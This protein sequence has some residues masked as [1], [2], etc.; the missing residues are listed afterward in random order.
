MYGSHTK[1]N[2]EL[3][4]GQTE[5]D[6]TYAHRIVAEAVNLSRAYPPGPVHINVP[7]REPFYPTAEETFTFDQAAK[8]ISVVSGEPTLS[9]DTVQALADDWARYEKKLIVGGQGIPDTELAKVIGQLSTSQRVPVVADVISNLHGAPSAVR[10]ADGLL[11]NPPSELSPDLLI[12]LGRSVISK[13]LKL[14][15]RKQRP[16]A[17]WQYSTGRYGGRYISVAH[18]GSARKSSDVF[19]SKCTPNCP[20]LL[21]HKRRTLPCG[22]PKSGTPGSA[23]ASYL[24]NR[25]QRT[26]GSFKPY[27][28]YCTICPMRSIC[29]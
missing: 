7:L 16:I 1:A 8:A 25:Q 21:L 22:K 15:L 12:T 18:T 19:F 5:A 11:T 23:S 13:D 20:L 14:F 4:V 26:W 24:P 3:P 27:R 2:Y 9:E 10:H 28:P 6:T 17:H 29:I